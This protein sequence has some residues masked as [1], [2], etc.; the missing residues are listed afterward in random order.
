MEK[1][2]K[3]RASHCDFRATEGEIYDALKRTTDPL[4]KSW[5]KL[6]KAKKVVLKFNMIKK[7]EAIA[8]FEGRRREL[9][10]DAVARAVLRLLRERTSAELIATDT[11]PYGNGFVTPED[12][13]YRHIL[14]E[15]GVKYVD[16]NLPPFTE[17][18]VPGGDPC[19]IP[20]S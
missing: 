11:F 17:F 13:N 15:Y 19:L 6:A 10:D 5:E 18:S 9:V 2:Y 16:S 4:D 14:E 12:F 8:Y 7:P 1:E 3:V 20:M